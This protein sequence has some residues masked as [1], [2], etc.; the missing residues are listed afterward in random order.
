M[1]PTPSENIKFFEYKKTRMEV[2]T[3]AMSLQLMHFIMLRL[4][5]S[6][7]FKN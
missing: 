4:R 2:E 5:F 1:L 6:F 7:I 3:D